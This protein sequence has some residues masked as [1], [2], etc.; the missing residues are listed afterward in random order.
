MLSQMLVW[1]PYKRATASSLLNHAYFKDKKSGFNLT[2]NDF[3]SLI[4]IEEEN[5]TENEIKNIKDL[6]ISKILNDSIG[7]NNCNKII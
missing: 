7:I 6:D 5:F 3:S 4:K 1:N 2:E